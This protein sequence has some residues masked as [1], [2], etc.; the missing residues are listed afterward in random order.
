MAH[1]CCICVV[2]QGG[3]GVRNDFSIVDDSLGL[4]ELNLDDIPSAME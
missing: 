2:H 1:I 4:D 3:F